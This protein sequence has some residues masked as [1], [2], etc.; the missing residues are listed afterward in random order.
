M[1]HIIELKHT[2]Q[3]LLTVFKDAR[4]NKNVMKAVNALREILEIE[5]GNP[6][7]P[8]S[9]YEMTDEEFLRRIAK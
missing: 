9:F 1:D 7:I 3:K 6:N 5:A 8:L 4:N 2:V